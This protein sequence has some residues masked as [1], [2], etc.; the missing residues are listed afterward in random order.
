M[1]IAIEPMVTAGKAAISFREDGW[2][3]DTR[4]G[5]LAAHFEHTVAITRDGHV[6]LTA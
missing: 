6:V 3:V 1:V 5:S 2:T 4:D